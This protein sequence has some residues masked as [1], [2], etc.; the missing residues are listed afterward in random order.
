MLPVVV[1]KLLLLALGKLVEDHVADCFLDQ[2]E[3]VLV[4][5]NP[6]T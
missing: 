3:E 6:S 2:F 4:E 5:E 1:E